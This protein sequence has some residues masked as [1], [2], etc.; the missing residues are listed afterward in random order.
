MTDLLAEAGSQ[1]TFNGG[2]QPIQIPVAAAAW[3]LRAAEVEAMSVVQ[4]RPVRVEP[5]ETVA[6]LPVS[7]GDVPVAYGDIPVA[8]GDIPVAYGDIPVAAGDIPLAYGDIPVAKG[9]IPLAYGDIPVATGDIPLAYGDIPVAKGDIPVAYGDVPVAYGDIPVMPGDV[10]VAYGDI[11]VAKGDIPVAFGDVPLSLGV[12]EGSV[13]S[14]G[15]PLAACSLTSPLPESCGLSAMVS[16]DGMVNSNEQLLPPAVTWDHAIPPPA[17]PL[18]VIHVGPFFRRGGAERWLL[19]L[20]RHADPR[21]LRFSRCICTE[22]SALDIGYLN[23]L[24][25]EGVI[26]EAGDADSVRHAAEEADV[27]LNWGVMLDRLLGGVQPRLAVQVVHGVG[28]MNRL[29]VSESRHS[30][31]HSIAVSHTV[32][33]RVVPDLPSTVIYNG[34]DARRL[35]PRHGARAMRARLGLSPNDFAVGFVGR[36]AA[37]KRVHL[38]ID[39]VARLP[40]RYKLVLAGWGSLYAPLREYANSRL[41]GRAVIVRVGDDVGDL[42]R[43]V[44]AVCL[45]SDQEGFPLV[46]LEAMHCRRPFVGTPVGGIPEIVA[47]RVNGLLTD[48]TPEHLSECL[49]ELG[50]RPRWAE[51]VAAE[52]AATAER[53][54]FAS[55]MA[56]DYEVLLHRLWN[57]VSAN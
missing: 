52:G 18:N 15:Q 9:D 33:A 17:R 32:R 51:G 35:A 10:P 37:E 29:C 50:E 49:S 27:L 14:G 28:P 30:V 19:D 8:T 55:R 56:R 3:E 13:L 41:P 40:S 24:S 44:D 57:E 43:A 39:A 53:F 6:T 46:M 12:C 7:E 34:I 31:S 16:L 4:G 5:Y 54:G 20:V 48:G 1:Y 11:P 21:Y 23:D 47:D 26:L 22:P 36:F 2:V 45:T 38:L 42:Y 25:G